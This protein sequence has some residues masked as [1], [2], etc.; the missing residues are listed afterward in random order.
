MVPMAIL[1]EN[2]MLWRNSGSVRMYL[3]G[4]NPYSSL[5]S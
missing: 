4:P 2:Q 3:Y 5:P 1:N